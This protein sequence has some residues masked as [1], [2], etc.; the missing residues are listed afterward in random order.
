MLT[1]AEIRRQMRARRDA[2]SAGEVAQRS[3]RIITRLLALPELIDAQTIFTYVSI[4]NEVRTRGLIEHLLAAGK[5]IAV[6]LIISRTEMKPVIITSLDDLRPGVLNIPEPPDPSLGPEPQAP[7][8]VPDLIILPGV[9]FT[10]TGQRLGMGGGH[11]DRY[12]AA[13]S[14]TPAIALCFQS[15]IVDE[16]PAEAHDQ[17]IRVV[18]NEVCEFRCA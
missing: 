15:Q 12:L 17:R 1:K 11:Y 9:A 13:H 6:P 10:A 3:E 16:L 5:T 8:P 4:G 7:G 2:M 14:D 18:V